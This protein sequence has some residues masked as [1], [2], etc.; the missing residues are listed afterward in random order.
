MNDPI[1]DQLARSLLNRC[2]QQDHDALT[3]LHRLV[4]RRIHAFVLPRLR[5]EDAAREVVSDTLHE[6]W[7]CAG[8]FRGDSLVSTWIFGIARNRM[9]AHW[10]QSS[11]EHAYDDIDDHAETLPSGLDDGEQALSRW[12]D[13]QIVNACLGELS[14]A[15]RECMQLV[16]L[17][18]MSLSEVAAV[19]QVPKGTVQSRLF[20]ARNS[21]RLCVQR[22]TGDNE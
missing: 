22:S 8:K 19:Q 12:Q 16:Y 10:R 20:H 17:E 13:R 11:R 5:D 18:G 7:K 6:A 14:P 9:L 4:A 1:D 3:A 15:H 21:M 2:A